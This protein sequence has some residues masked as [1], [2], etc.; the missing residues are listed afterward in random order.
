MFLEIQDFTKDQIESIFNRVD[1]HG[2]VA[3][4]LPVACSFEGRGICTKT[5]FYQVIKS[6]GL[7]YIEF[8]L[9]LD[10]ANYQLRWDTNSL[11]PSSIK[12]RPGTHLI[13]LARDLLDF[14]QTPMSPAKI[15]RML[16]KAMVMTA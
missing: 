15:P 16:K 10:T 6:L 1:S 12:T 5:S 4:N 2:T 3:S 11:T 14:S 8:P 9:L 13:L 7:D